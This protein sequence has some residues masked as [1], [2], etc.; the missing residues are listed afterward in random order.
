MRDLRGIRKYI[1]EDNPQQAQIFAADIAAK[2]TWIA[3]V[4]FTGSPRDHISEGLRGFPYRKRCIYYRSL[5][6]KVVVIRVLHSAQDIAKQ[7]F[8]SEEK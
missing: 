8:G 7:Q 5:S 4:D 3:E 2:I 1:A 6:D